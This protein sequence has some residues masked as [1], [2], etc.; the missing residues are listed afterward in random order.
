MTH[1]GVVDQKMAV[2]FSRF[3]HIL[4]DLQAKDH[5]S[6]PGQHLDIFNQ[7]KSKQY[8]TRTSCET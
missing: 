3:L 7:G 2:N 5:V 1:T 4:L 8:I 6:I